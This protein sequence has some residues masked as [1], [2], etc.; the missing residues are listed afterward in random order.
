MKVASLERRI[1]PA[2]ARSKG[3]HPGDDRTLSRPYNHPLESH[4]H[5]LDL[6]LRSPRSPVGV[7]V[8]AIRQISLAQP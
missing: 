7:P 4:H 8:L 6:G 1:P 2:R 5:R 3:S